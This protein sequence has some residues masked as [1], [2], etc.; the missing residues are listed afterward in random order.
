MNDDRVVSFRPKARPAAGRVT[1][2][3]DALFLP[4]SKAHHGPQWAFT[5][6]AK[7]DGEDAPVA[8]HAAL[9]G[10]VPDEPD[11]M[12]YLDRGEDGFS[13]KFVVG[14]DWEEAIRL[15]AF[16]TAPWDLQIS[17]AVDAEGDVVR[18]SLAMTRRR[19]EP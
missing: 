4:F 17:F 9:V 7:V 14:H 10:A 18:V 19:T 2:S 12:G 13:G 1:L 16:S 6:Q 8:I 3:T 5:A 11:S 15:A